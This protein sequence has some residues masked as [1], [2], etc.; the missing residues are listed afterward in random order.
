M[1][2][3]RG[4]SS[5]RKIEPD[6]SEPKETTATSRIELTPLDSLLSMAN[7]R[8]PKDHSIPDLIAS[9]RRFGFVA[10]P[11]IDEATTTMVAGHGRCQALAEM[12]ER[13]EAP[14]AN[15]EIDTTGMWMVPVLR[16][17]SFESERERDAFT[18]A[19]NQ[20][21]IHGGWNF[22]LLSSMLKRIKSEGGAFDGMGFDDIDLRSFGI[23]ATELADVADAMTDGAGKPDI[24]RLA[25]H[26]AIAQD[27]VPD[28][29]KVPITKRGDV[30]LLGDSVLICDDCT[31]VDPARL[32]IGKLGFALTS[33][34]YNAGVK[35]Y[36][37]N[38]RKKEGR[39]A[40]KESR[41]LDGD[42]SMDADEYAALLDASTKVLLESAHVAAINL[43]SLAQNKR[44][45]ARWVAR[46]A[47]HLVDRAIWVKSNG[48]PAI[49][50]NVMNSAFEDIYFFANERRAKR[51][52]ATASFHGTVKNWHEGP[53]AS[54]VNDY[55]DVHGATMAVHLAQ[56]II[57]SHGALAD[58][59][60]DPFG[61]T[62][63]TMIV[64]VQLGKR[65]ALIEM[66]PSYCDIIVERW[67]RVTGGQ[68]VRGG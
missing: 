21:T 28:P 62:G 7:T 30:W 2:T 38:A 41:Y 9:F 11:T 5:N 34:P 40:S 61:G 54:R 50:R 6:Q 16:G 56:W 24:N 14:P 10:P 25:P 44:V 48:S 67:S 49:A 52:I 8:N 22:D 15:V 57:E 66:D 19:D 29:P 47:D 39:A 53:S 60:V 12:R 33:P 43:Q 1:S 23:D 26:G 4:R 31:T 64:A 37:E 3:V 51:S 42:D 68:A 45:I 18:I 35:L 27:E 20:S 32:R 63:T 17:I 36:G 65:A 46:F 13:N 58:Y 59:V 55:S